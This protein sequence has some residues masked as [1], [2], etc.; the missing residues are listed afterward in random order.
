[1]LF[2]GPYNDHGWSQAHYE[3]GKYVEAKIPGA[4]MIYVDKVNPADRP[5]TTPEQLAEDLVAQGAKMIF[6]TSDDM[7]DGALAFAKA[8]P[9]IPVSSLSGDSAWKDGKDFQN[10]PNLSN[11]MGKMEYG[12][13]IAGVRRRPDHPDRQDRLP[14]PADQR[15]DPP[16]GRLRLPGRPVRLDRIPEARTRPT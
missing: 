4:K 7:K 15:R 6:F 3:G 11:F 5:G 12:K 10:L 14:R 9:D 8:H 16:P 1:M 2:V 13:M